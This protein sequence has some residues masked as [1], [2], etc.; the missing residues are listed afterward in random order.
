MNATKK[1]IG[2]LLLICMFLRLP[3]AEAVAED[4]VDDFVAATIGIDY[5]LRDSEQTDCSGIYTILS[6]CSGDM[7]IIPDNKGVV[8]VNVNSRVC[9]RGLL[10]SFRTAAGPQALTRGIEVYWKGKKKQALC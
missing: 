7:P 4:K 3:K 2:C 9:P 8:I 1:M 6:P 10:R 5:Q